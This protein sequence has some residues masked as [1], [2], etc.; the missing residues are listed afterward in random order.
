MQDNT[1]NNY[2]IRFT[3]I[4]PL[5]ADGSFKIVLPH[6]VSLKDG[7]NT[8]CFVTTNKLFADKCKVSPDDDHVLLVT[9][10]FETAA[11]YGSEIVI[12]VQNVINPSDNKPDIDSDG[13]PRN[14]FNLYT[15]GDKDMKYIQD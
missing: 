8:K 13:L 4:N 14:G 10:V 12:M 2:T 5:P 1:P 15:Y 6:D 7:A 3:P 9:G 11:P